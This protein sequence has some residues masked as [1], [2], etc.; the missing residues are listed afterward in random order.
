MICGVAFTHAVL[1]LH[2]PG[3]LIHFVPPLYISTISI[4]D[5]QAMTSMNART[6][7]SKLSTECVYDSLNCLTFSLDDEL[8]E[9]SNVQLSSGN[10]PFRLKLSHLITLNAPYHRGIHRQSN[11]QYQL[12]HDST[13]EDVIITFCFGAPDSVPTASMTLTTS[14]PSTASP[15][16]TCRPSS[17]D[18]TVVVMKN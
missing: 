2:V 5:W 15:N 11:V 6:S 12:N 14:M 13:P 17:H 1:Y 3:T 7:R 8:I 4:L 18:V 16:T 10:V 9:K